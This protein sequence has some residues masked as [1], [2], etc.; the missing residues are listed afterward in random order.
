MAPRASCSDPDGQGAAGD[1]RVCSAAPLLCEPS[2]A[3]RSRMRTYSPWHVHA[4]IL[5]RLC[6][7]QEEAVTQ[8]GCFCFR[9]KETEALGG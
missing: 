4:H 8:A 9:D 5:V 6:Y 3:G 1:A 2:P 7:F